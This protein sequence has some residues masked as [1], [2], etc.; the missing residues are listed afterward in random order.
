MDALF[1]LTYF[2]GI[3][4]AGTVFIARPGLLNKTVTGGANYREFLLP[5]PGWTLL[6]AIKV[7]FWPVVL[8]FWA[9]TLFRPSPWK[10]TVEID[11]REV[12]KIRRIRP[13]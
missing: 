1:F 3:F 4:V 9:I 12:R 10:A 6:W 8:A 11:G 2:V 7:L 5:N 13:W